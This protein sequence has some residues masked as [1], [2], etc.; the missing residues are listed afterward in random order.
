MIANV[1]KVAARVR[2]SVALTAL[3]GGLLGGCAVND[4]GAA[5][6]WDPIETPNRFVF[7]INRALDVMMLRPITVL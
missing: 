1:F 6:V 2:R 5:E 7:S 4:T 3:A